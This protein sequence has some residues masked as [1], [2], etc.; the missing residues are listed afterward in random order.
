MDVLNQVMFIHLKK[1][2]EKDKEKMND[3]IESVVS[4]EEE[5]TADVELK[6][7]IEKKEKMKK[8]KKK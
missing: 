5:S 8:N 4:N 3:H 6:K 2:E 1:K 7:E